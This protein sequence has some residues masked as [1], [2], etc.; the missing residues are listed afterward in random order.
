[1]AKS[2]FSLPQLIHLEISSTSWVWAW[3]VMEGLERMQLTLLRASGKGSR[4]KKTM[5]M[6]SWESTIYFL[7]REIMTINQLIIWGTKRH[8]WVTALVQLAQ[9]ARRLLK[10]LNENFIKQVLRKK[11]GDLLA[12]L[13]VHRVKTGSRLGHSNYIG[14]SL[15]SV[16]T[17][18]KVPAKR[19]LWT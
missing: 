18:G 12:L 4:D 17:G 5:W 6:S 16:L 13:L 1:M 7:A 10:N 9:Q 14:S 3:Y 8:F 11:K 19:Q 15:K 2:Y